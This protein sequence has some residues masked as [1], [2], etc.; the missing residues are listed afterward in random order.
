MHVGVTMKE[1]ERVGRNI[2]RHKKLKAIF[3]KKKCK[4]TINISKKLL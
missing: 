4:S 2:L 1:T 3:F